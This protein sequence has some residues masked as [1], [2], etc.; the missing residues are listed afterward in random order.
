MIML[1][2][3][4]MLIGGLHSLLSA[5]RSLF[6]SPDDDFFSSDFVPG[7]LEVFLSILGIISFVL[8]FFAPIY[9]ICRFPGWKGVVITIAADIILFIIVG[10][11]D[12]D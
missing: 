9:I 7:F 5:I 2:F 3:C 12:D 4:F 11:L 1:P 6:S 10:F 8:S